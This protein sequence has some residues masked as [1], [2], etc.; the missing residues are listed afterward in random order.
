[1]CVSCTGLPDCVSGSACDAGVVES[2]RREAAKE[3]TLVDAASLGEARASWRRS[4]VVAI[5][6][7]G[8]GVLEVGFRTL[9]VV[10]VVVV[11]CKRITLIR[12]L[13]ET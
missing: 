7:G 2:V 8:G 11:G 9:H 12:S 10:V 5:L 4:S 3:G 1:M 6:A 13:G